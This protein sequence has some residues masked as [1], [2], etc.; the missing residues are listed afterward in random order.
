MANVNMAE[1]RTTLEHCV[2]FC[3]E[4]DD[5]EYCQRHGP[6]LEDALEDLESSRR[7]TDAYFTEWRRRQRE[8]KIAWKEL[9]GQ[10][11]EA[12]QKLDRVD[13]FGYP[14][15]RLMYWDEER[16]EEGLEEMIDYLRE[17][18]DE[19]EFADE[20]AETLQRKLEMAHQDVEE[21]EEAL[22]DYRNKIKK[23]SDAMGGAA[24]VIGD[25]RE[26]LRDELGAEDD[27]YQSIRWP[28]GVSPDE[29][30]F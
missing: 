7:E 15:E 3:R 26:L 19:F 13:A 2:E 5:R 14:D 27:E 10:L 18:T 4:H 17:Q 24:Q 6:R 11:R 12:Q 22:D 29:A 25:F 28:Y 16:L 9:A 20:L 8:Q 23:R 30:T 21:Q 1:L